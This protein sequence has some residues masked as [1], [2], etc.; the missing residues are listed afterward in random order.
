MGSIVVVV[1]LVTVATAIFASRTAAIPGTVQTTVNLAVNF[2]DVSGECLDCA[3]RMF[4]VIVMSVVLNLRL[5]ALKKPMDPG[6]VT[7]DFATSCRFRTDNI[8]ER[9]R[10]LIFTLLGRDDCGVG[11]RNLTADCVGCKEMVGHLV[12]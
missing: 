1:A 3:V 12:V 9:D 5:K 11:G 8:S 10:C 4:G 2:D 6:V 7:V